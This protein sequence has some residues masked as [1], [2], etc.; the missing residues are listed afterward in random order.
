MNTTSKKNKIFN[1]A[2]TGILAAIIALMSFTPIGYLK[3]PVIEIT[4]ITVPVVIGAISLGPAGGAVLGGVFGLT[5]FIQCFGMS[6]FGAALFQINPFF[7]ALV[8]FIPRILMGFL[9]GL[10]FNAL[11]KTKLNTFFK[12]FIPS[13]LGPLFNTL[14]FTGLLVALFWHTSYIQAL[15]VKLGGTVLKF[16]VGFVGLNGLIEALVCTVLGTAIT[17]PLSKAVKNFGK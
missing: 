1:L 12:F 2:L 17:I 3:T 5:S 13:L 11:K 16:A 6:A 14:F 15:A 10:I 7:T 9:C 8:C 4:F